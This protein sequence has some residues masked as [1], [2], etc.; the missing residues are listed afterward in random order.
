MKRELDLDAML[1][2]PIVRLMMERDG[3]RGGDVRQLFQKVKSARAVQERA[4]VREEVPAGILFGDADRGLEV[5]A[6]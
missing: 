2:E 6:S 5:S 1:R 4:R 3:I